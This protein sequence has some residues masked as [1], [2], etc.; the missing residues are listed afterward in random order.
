[1]S[2]GIPLP[3][4]IPPGIR[5]RHE[6]FGAGLVE[7]DLGETVFVRFDHGLERCPRGE[8]RVLAGLSEV[9]D[10]EEWDRTP[11]VINR[12]QAEAILSVNDT[13]GVFSRSRIALLPHQLWV[14][15][16]VQES[17]PTHWLVADDVGLGKTIEAGLILAPLIARGQ[18]KRALIL[19]PASLVS[20]WS[21]RLFRL[22]DLNFKAYRAEE[23]R[24]AD[25]FWQRNPFVVA[26]LQ[27]LRMDN[28]GRKQRLLT[29]GPWDML[30]VDEAHHLNVDEQTGATSAYRLVKEMLDA[31][32]LTSRVFFTGTPHRGKDY[33]FYAL[34]HLVRPDLFSTKVPLE[35]QLAGLRSSLIRNNKQCVTD[36]KGNLLFKKPIVRSVEY[37][38]TAAESRFYEA[39]S[40]FIVDGKAYSKRLARESD[41]RTVM[42]VLIAMQKIASSSIAAIRKALSSRLAKVGQMAEDLAR[43]EA[44][45]RELSELA[46]LPDQGDR[47]GELDE[48]ILEA[49]GALHLME[50][51]EPRLLE[52]LKLAADIGVETKIR[53]LVD[54]TEREFG[55]R[56]VVFFTEYKA[57]QAELMGALQ[58]HFGD[59]CSVFINGDNALPEVRS[60]SGV[61][62]PQRMNRVEAASRFNEA[63]ARFIISTEAGGEGIDLQDNCWT[64]VH[65]DL[66]WNP[67]RLHQRVGRVN[68]YGQT[69][70]VEVV[71][72]RNPETVETRIWDL[73]NQKIARI[74]TALA[75]GMD[76]PEDLLELVL[77]MTRPDT[78]REMFAEAP[79]SEG[80]ALSD[81]FDRRTTLF[82]G[83]DVLKAVKSLVGHSERFDFAKTSRMLP[84]VDLEHLEPF[85]RL[86]LTLQGKQVRSLGDGLRVLTPESWFPDRE[87]KKEW[88]R[89]VFDRKVTGS[90]AISRVL[91]VGHPLMDRCLVEA[92]GLPDVASSTLLLP[93]GE[94]WVAFGV[95]DEATGRKGAV[96]VGTVAVKIL[97]TGQCCLLRDWELLISLNMLT[98][99]LS[100]R[101][102]Q[103]VPP[104]PVERVQ[105]AVDHATTHLAGHLADLELGFLRPRAHVSAVLWGRG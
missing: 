102:E 101:G 30:M 83:D 96:K 20:Q 48:Q 41:A 86:H 35:Q 52:L 100:S 77:G 2:E 53:A 65:V 17:W 11:A 75:E 80:Q 32:L 63:K 61:V 95:V 66:P 12:M 84:Q 54:L 97:P 59:G 92:Q 91:A 68:R 16:R 55:G 62:R 76:E 85:F 49:A 87:L 29:S 74:N 56:Q 21:E 79:R 90:Y 38:Y 104:I 64:L 81:W 47:L 43:L 39:M 94:A 42:L 78:F 73:L 7:H 72:F 36:L 19:C 14:C 1:M 31:D 105:E 89:L 70:Q 99:R 50:H 10:R 82:G 25:A 98:E 33:G 37:R 58:A 24:P 71:L 93:D 45:R 44:L 60:Q 46:D 13:W 3:A 88:T 6:T 8:L 23:D 15:K 18:V 103:E 9:I 69:E 27:T 34:M 51:E 40:Q 26:S 22:F 67:M 4:A 57:T 5:V 28:S